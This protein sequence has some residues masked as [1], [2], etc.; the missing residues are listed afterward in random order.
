[1]FLCWFHQ[2]IESAKTYIYYVLCLQVV[3]T[4]SARMLNSSGFVTSVMIIDR[5][6][7]SVRHT[8]RMQF[9]RPKCRPNFNLIVNVCT[10]RLIL[11]EH[12]ST[13]KRLP[14]RR[15]EFETFSIQLRLPWLT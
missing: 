5:I 3:A 8:D 10:R 14:Q 1:M 2:V 12:L 9:C 13:Q 6:I 15:M 7:R 11:H 4:Q